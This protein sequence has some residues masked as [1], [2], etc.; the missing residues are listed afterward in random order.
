MDRFLAGRTRR[1]LFQFNVRDLYMLPLEFSTTY[2]V[3]HQ[4]ASLDCNLA[5]S[6]THEIHRYARAQGSVIPRYTVQH[7]PTH[8]ETLLEC[9]YTTPWQGPL[10]RAIPG[11]LY[12]STFAT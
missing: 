10:P 8:H 11:C 1:R 4:E 5:L 12:G 2:G 6:G 9:D 7:G 3:R